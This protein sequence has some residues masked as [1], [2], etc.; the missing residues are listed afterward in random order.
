MK[1]D[2]L[3]FIGNARQRRSEKF[4]HQL[5]IFLICLV[6]A[7]FIWALV[8]LSKD[9]YYSIEYHLTYTQI[10]ANLRILSS[11]DSTIYLRI[12]IQGFE[13]F[14]EQFII[15]QYREYEVSLRN[16]RL[17]YLGEHTLGYL[18]TNRIGKEIISQTNF[19]S[20]VYFVSPDTL[21]F[22]FGKS[23]RRPSPGAAA[24][25]IRMEVSGR[26]TIL[27]RTDSIGKSAGHRND[28]KKQH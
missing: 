27:R 28:Y 8:R 22:E 16:V 24:D 10:P 23:V 14:S 13:F 18:L 21:F 20:E 2:F 9:Y 25:A 12:K 1:S 7:V 11:S 26:D 6:L 3:E 5:Y 15:R 4:R 17:R 19:P